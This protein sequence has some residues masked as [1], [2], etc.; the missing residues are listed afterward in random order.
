MEDAAIPQVLDLDGGVDPGHHREGLDRAVAG[1]RCDCDDLPW[2]QVV[3]NRDVED[4]AA[5]EA[6]RVGVIAS[7]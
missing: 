5:V 6:E 7:R 3:T 2:L 4:L 1:G